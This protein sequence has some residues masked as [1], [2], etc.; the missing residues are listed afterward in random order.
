[1]NRATFLRKFGAFVVGQGAGQIIAFAGALIVLRSLPTSDYAFFVFAFGFQ[2]A[3]AVIVDSG[4]SNSIVA[5]VGPEVAD[6]KAVGMRLHAAMACRRQMLAPS[7]IVVVPAFLFFGERLGASR[8]TIL[9]CLVIM[10]VSLVMQNGLM[11]TAVLRMVGDVRSLFRCV[12]AGA[13]G[14]L[15]AIVA[16][17]YADLLTT[18]TALATNILNLMI[19]LGLLRNAVP[20]YATRPDE[21]PD[22]MKSEARRYI[23]PLLPGAIFQGVQGQLSVFVGGALG[24]T[25]SVAE[26]GALARIGQ[27]GIFITGFNGLFLEPVFAR[28]TL[29]RARR[30]LGL[31]SAVTALGCAGLVLCLEMLPGITGLVL[32]DAY[33]G[34]TYELQLTFVAVFLSAIGHQVYLMNVA[35]RFL[36][37]WYTLATIVTAV[38]SQI[39]CIALVDTS[40]TSGLIAISIVGAGSGLLVHL[41]ALVVGS[42]WG[43]RSL[44]GPRHRGPRQRNR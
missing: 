29:K 38:V 15:V 21:L 26:V 6:K 12:N 11:Q 19:T 27:I 34:L 9:I 42:I 32:G 33:A 44:T 40:T 35:R 39:A 43:P 18:E 1:M 24:A 5:L 23:A 36:Y 3:I 4:V 17:E 30:I 22:D 41:A 28:T 14:R 7:L 25:R 2:S 8:S 13:V 20:K 16:L 31:A 10:V 37:W